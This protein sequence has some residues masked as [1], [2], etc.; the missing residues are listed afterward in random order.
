MEWK[1]K[2][3]NF[4]AAPDGACL[5]GGMLSCS[6]KW[7]TLSL[8]FAATQELNKNTPT[9]TIAM[10]TST[11]NNERT[12]GGVVEC[13]L[14][15]NLGPKVHHSKG[16]PLDLA[17]ATD[18]GKHATTN[19]VGRKCRKKV[20]RISIGCRSSGL[21]KSW[22]LFRLHDF[23]LE[24]DDE[25]SKLADELWA[26]KSPPRGAWGLVDPRPEGG[27]ENKCCWRPLN[28]LESGGI[29]KM[30]KFQCVGVCV[31]KKGW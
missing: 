11:N 17:S 7:K 2:N 22:I 20:E 30:R 23:W 8:E 3:W 6:E 21:R 19:N 29:P 10:V 9:P 5:D 16:F 25:T 13:R 26:C 12:N 1:K 15:E 4:A 28:M 18:G 24:E 27:C 14:G 31:G